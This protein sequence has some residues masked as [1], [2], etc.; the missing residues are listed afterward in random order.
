ML[1]ADKENQILTSLYHYHIY[2]GHTD[3]LYDLDEG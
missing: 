2:K 1:T 3:I